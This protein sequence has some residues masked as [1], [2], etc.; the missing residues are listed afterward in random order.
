MSEM[1]YIGRNPIYLITLI[2]FMALQPAV[3]YAKNFGMLLAFR[4]LTGIFGSPALAT[5][6]ASLADMYSPDKIQ[7]SM[8]I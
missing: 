3:I 8:S 1:P 4:F 5:G 6:G 2:I 7:Y